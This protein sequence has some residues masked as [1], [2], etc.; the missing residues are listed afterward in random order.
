MPAV[1]PTPPPP[2]KEARKTKE[3]QRCIH[4]MKEFSN[5]KKAINHLMISPMCLVGGLQAAVEK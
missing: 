2:A 5:N 1:K 3:N 4:C